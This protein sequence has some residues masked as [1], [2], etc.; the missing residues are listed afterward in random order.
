MPFTVAHSQA[1]LCCRLDLSLPKSP[2]GCQRSAKP[3]IR[4]SAV[5]TASHKKAPFAAGVLYG[6][7]WFLTQLIIFWDSPGSCHQVC[8]PREQR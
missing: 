3:V 4:S 2:F 7:M 5:T 6:G 1:R 8:S